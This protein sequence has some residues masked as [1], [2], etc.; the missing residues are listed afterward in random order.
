MIACPRTARSRW[1]TAQPLL[2]RDPTGAPDNR[3]AEGRLRSDTVRSRDCRRTS[4]AVGGRCACTV[5]S[6]PSPYA[7]WGGRLLRS[8]PLISMHR[9][10]TEAVAAPPL[11]D[12]SRRVETCGERSSWNVNCGRS[13]RRRGR[14]PLVGGRA[15]WTIQP[16][17]GQL[18]TRS[19]KRLSAKPRRRRPMR[20]S[21]RSKHRCTTPRRCSSCP[22]AA[23]WRAIW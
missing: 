5:V 3:M 14:R 7:P 8:A 15:W 17:F 4:R 12:P 2:P 6:A 1:Q 13:L 23:G 19:S 22:S 11:L 20:R 18:C 16:R 21:C 10:S 9:T